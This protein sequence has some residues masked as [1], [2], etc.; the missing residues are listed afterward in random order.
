M[1]EAA[2]PKKSGR[3]GARPGAGRPKG[4][5]RRERWLGPS[6]Q[7]EKA[8]FALLPKVA[9]ALERGIEKGDMQ[10]VALALKYGLVSAD[11][12]AK[13]GVEANGS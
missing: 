3:G 1:E 4:S 8:I 13:L 11:A 10:A 7:A 6:V 12:R 9:E 2:G 5:T